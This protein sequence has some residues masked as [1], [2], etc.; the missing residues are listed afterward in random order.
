MG[1]VTVFM[2]PIFTGGIHVIRFVCFSFVNLSFIM[3]GW[4]SAKNLKVERENYFS[5]LCGVTNAVN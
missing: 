2:A 4:V 5:Q 3:G 1:A